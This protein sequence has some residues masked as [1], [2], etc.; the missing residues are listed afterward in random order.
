MFLPME[1]NIENYEEK[2]KTQTNKR[3][4]LQS[5]EITLKFEPGILKS[6]RNLVDY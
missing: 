3:A 1:V 2:T 4:P 6:T 5:C